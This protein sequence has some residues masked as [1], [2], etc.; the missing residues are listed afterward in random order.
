MMLS[1]SSIHAINMDYRVAEVLMRIGGAICGSF[2]LFGGL[3]VLLY[4]PWRRRVD[5]IR[6]RNIRQAYPES[7]NGRDD[8]PATE[9]VGEIPEERLQPIRASSGE[10]AHLPS[11]ERTQK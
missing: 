5:K 10:I 6:Q 9:P 8:D 3:S 2:V 4:R 11:L 1:V 7:D